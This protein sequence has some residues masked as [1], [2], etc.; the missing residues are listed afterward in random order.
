MPPRQSKPPRPYRDEESVHGSGGEAPPPPPPPPPPFPPPL[1]PPMPDL[2][3]FVAA[4][5]AAIPDLADKLCCTK[6]QRVNYAGLSLK[7]EAR[8]WW[9]ATKTLLIEELGRGVPITWERFKKKFNDCF[10]PQAHRQQCAREFQD[11]NQGAMSVEQYSAKFLKLS[12]YA[13]RFIPDEETKIERFRDGLSPQILERVICFKVT[14]YADMVHMATMV[15]KGIKNAI[16]DFV[17]RKQSMSLGA[18]PSPPSKRHVTS[19]SAGPIVSRDTSGS[20]GSGNYPQCSKCGRLHRGKCKLGMKVCFKCGKTGHF[21]RECP[22][23]SMGKGQESQ[24]SVN[25]PRQTAPAR[26]FALTPDNVIAEDNIIGVVTVEGRTLPA[27]LAVFSM[28]GFDVILGMDWL[29]EYKANIDFHRKEVTFRPYGMEEFKFQGSRVRATPPLLFA[30][31]AIKRVREGAQAYLAYVQAKPE[32]RVK[33]ED[34]PVPIDKAPYRM[35]PTELS[36]LK[37]QLQELLDQGFI[38]PSVSSWGAPVLFVKKKD[39]SMQMCIDYREL[40]RIDLLSGY[41]QLRVREKDIPKTAIRTRYG[42]YNFL[43]MPFGLTNAPSVFM[44]LMNRVF[45]EYLDSFVVVFIEDILVYS[46]NHVE[47][48]VHLKTVTGKLGEK[49]LF[50]KLKKCEFWLE[51][52]SFLGHV[53]SK[54]GL[55]VDPAKVQAVVE[56]ERPTS[57]REIRSFL[58]LAS[59]YKRFIEGFSSLS[60]PFTTL[61]KKNAPFIWSDTCEARFQE[62][63]RRLVTAPVLTLP[64]ESV[65]YVVYTNASKKGLGCVLMQQDRVVAYA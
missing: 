56:W 7:G 24:T 17:N 57:L 47:H 11:L 28:L 53:A 64:M 9:K 22:Q 65:G 37:K 49:K 33:L 8:H 12:R 1:P 23:A 14:D 34:I 4:L 39:G 15:D 27:K 61:T 51:E 13:P 48:E 35:A 63:K 10:F 58:G 32:A 26:V 6:D 52:V 31:Q 19:S 21:I 40:N 42:D 20:Q 54:N 3:Q 30:V 16:A 55:T 62:L 46:T 45:H 41:H 43:V 25:Q 5:I 50:A 29:L 2:G 38:R 59:Y 36:E 60:G 44:D 18:P